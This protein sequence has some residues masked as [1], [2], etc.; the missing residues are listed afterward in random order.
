[1]NSTQ[2]LASVSL[3][4]LAF[5]FGGGGNDYDMNW[6][7]IDSGGGISVGDDFEVHGSIGQHDA[8][9]LLTGDDFTL[10]GGFRAGGAADP[11]SE[12]AALFDFQIIEGALLGGG[13]PELQSSDDSYLHTRSGFGET[14]I[15]L[16]HMEMKVLASTTINNPGT[17][18][19]TI[20][21]RIDDA[22]GFSEIRLFNWNTRQY[23][24][25][26]QHSLGLNDAVHLFAGLDANA[27]VSNLGEVDVKMKH[28]VFVPFLAYTFQSFID[29]VEIAVN[30]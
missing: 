17:I 21:T 30:E 19:L 5:G 25:V 13:L 12:I 20:E 8:G 23:I 14:L 28:I 15:D 2:T 24:M 26:G 10:A 29:Q 1:M 16:H 22:S 4:I 9:P 7:T 18:D 27:Y 6:F 11:G 3:A